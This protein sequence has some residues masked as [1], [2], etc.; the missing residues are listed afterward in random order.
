M[1]NIII[2]NNQFIATVELAKKQREKKEYGAFL[3]G[4]LQYK[5][6]TSCFL[7]LFVHPANTPI[8]FK[9]FSTQRARL[10]L[11]GMKITRQLK[12]P[13]FTR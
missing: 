4:S 13:S 6:A 8:I 2:K 9:Y 10:F 5:A 11:T 12:A 3:G 1:A 7:K